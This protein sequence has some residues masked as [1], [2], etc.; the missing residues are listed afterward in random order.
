[1]PRIAVAVILSLSLQLAAQ[2]ASTSTTAS[3]PK[4]RAITGFVRLDRATSEKQIA[5]AL[6]VLRKVKS[7]F[8]AAGYQVES[9]RLQAGEFT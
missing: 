7:E 5:E 3:N 2:T 1:M 6:V 4:V 8:E 9:L